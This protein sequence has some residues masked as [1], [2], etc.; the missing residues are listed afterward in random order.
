MEVTDRDGSQGEAHNL[1]DRDGISK[2]GKSGGRGINT[3]Y[4]IIRFV[5]CLCEYL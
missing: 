2:K 3:R 1:I 5:L 4:T